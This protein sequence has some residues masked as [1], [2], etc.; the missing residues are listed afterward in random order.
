M[1][2]NQYISTYDSHIYKYYIYYTNQFNI[3]Q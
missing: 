3:N 1:N 2:I